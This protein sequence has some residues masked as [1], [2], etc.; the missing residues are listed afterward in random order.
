VYLLRVVEMMQAAIPNANIPTVLLPAAAPDLLTAVAALPAL[1][2]QPEY[3][4]LLRVVE[5]QGA[6][7]NANIPKVPSAT[8]PAIGH[9]PCFVQ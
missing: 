3:V 7:P 2:T 8:L 1:T 9:R 4:Y 5:A 6:F